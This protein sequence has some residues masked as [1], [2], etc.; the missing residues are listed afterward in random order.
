[1]WSWFVKFGMNVVEGK[2]ISNWYFSKEGNGFIKGLL[3][4]LNVK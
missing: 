4:C 3:I 1:M 2:L